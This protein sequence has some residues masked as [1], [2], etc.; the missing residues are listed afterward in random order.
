MRSNEKEGVLSQFRRG[1]P[2]TC[3]M[4]TELNGDDCHRLFFKAGGVLRDESEYIE[5]GRRALQALLD[6]EASEID[7]FRYDFL[8]DDDTW[9]QA[10]ETGPNPGLR[11][12]IPLSSNDARLNIVLQDVLGDLYDIVWWASAMSRGG[13]GIQEMQDFLQG[14][15]P[16]TLADDPEFAKRRE[17]L[18]K[19]MAAVVKESKV[20]FSEP[21]GMVC[22][23]RA[24]G[25][26]QSSG[27]LTA[28]N[29]IVDRPQPLERGAVAGG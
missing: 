27:K 16:T 8:D 3:I 24:S 5:I 12:L 7:R 1:G 20:R 10:V 29:L 19:L 13:K 4:R 2:S 6:P 11:P 23:F 28:E 18:Q 25:G 22:L 17:K 9:R 21:W 26:R 15:D 14:R